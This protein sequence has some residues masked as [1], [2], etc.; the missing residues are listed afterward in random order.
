VN[1]DG[2]LHLSFYPVPSGSDFGGI[3]FGQGNWVLRKKGWSHANKPP[4]SSGRN[5]VIFEYLGDPVEPPSNMDAAYS[6]L[7]LHNAIQIA[8]GNAGTS[9]QKLVIDDS[10]FPFLIGVVSEPG[11]F[12]KLAGQLKKMNGY[13][14]GG[15]VGSPTLH[16]FNIVPYHSFPPEASQRISRR[17]T[18]RQ[19]ILFDKISAQK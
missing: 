7:G 15:S 9:L 1:E 6:R 12:D 13:E 17:L 4:S 16:S 14:Y 19:Q 5:Q 2:Y 18:L 3:Y 8:A 11:D 10:E